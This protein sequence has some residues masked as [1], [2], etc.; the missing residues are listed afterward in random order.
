ML[1]EYGL[2]W[3]PEGVPF[4][5]LHYG[6]AFPNEKELANYTRNFNWYWPI[7]SENRQIKLEK[8][9]GE[10]PP[11]YGTLVVPTSKI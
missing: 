9:V 3:Y 6:I 1:E 10:I 8:V 2:D 4:A 7:L 5:V 11:G